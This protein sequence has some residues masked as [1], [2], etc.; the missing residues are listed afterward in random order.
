MKYILLIIICMGVLML[1]SLTI[2]T[3]EG[4]SREVSYDALSALPMQAF[5]T[6]SLKD[7]SRS[8]WQG[9]RFDKWLRDNGYNDFKR[10][11]FEAEDRYMTMLE[12]SEFDT[13]ECWLAFSSEGK[14]FEDKSMRVIFPGTR[15]M[16]WVSF[17]ARVVLEGELPIVVPQ[18]FM[19]ID[20]YLKEF[21]LHRDPTPF[22]D[23]EGWLFREFLPDEILRNGGELYILSRDG[24]SSILSYPKHLQDAVLEYREGG[25]HMKSPQI[26]GGMWLRDVVFIQMGEYALIN[27]YH[28][29][30]LI[31]LSKKLDW[32]LG[33][34]SKWRLVKGAESK[35]IP[36]SSIFE[37]KLENFDYFELLP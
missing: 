7:K 15:E 19:L 31:E 23:I 16:K 34:N 20:S 35:E 26:P 8:L 5:A 4:M 30:I 37:V 14:I 32:K 36:F 3:C 1:H 2:I 11:R 24:V 21:V 22:V 29:S 13:L 9:I 18:G 27:K 10:I 17:V 25:Y 6:I 33:A 12:K 28:L